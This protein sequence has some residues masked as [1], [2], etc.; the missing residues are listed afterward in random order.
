MLNL[1]KEAALVAVLTATLLPAAAHAGLVLDTGTPTVS[2]LP[3]VLDGN[4]YYAAE[5]SLSAGQTVN[6]ISAYLKAGVDQPG[7]TFSL[8][9]YS[10]ADFG[11]R[12]ATPVFLGQATYN[13]DGWTGISNVGFTATASGL[14]WAAVEVGSS[15]SAIG[16][17]LPSPVSGGT[18]AALAYAFNS[19]SGYTTSGAMPFGIQ[20]DAS[21]AP[22]PLPAALWLLGSGVVS[23]GGALRRRQSV[24]A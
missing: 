19:G 5:F 10:N 21:A 6:S 12:N 9:L 7:D 20:V 11:S 22:V 1:R 2:A 4:D 18:V 14:Y 17:N 15:D 8:V 3:L 23:L 16:L 24:Q 13:Q